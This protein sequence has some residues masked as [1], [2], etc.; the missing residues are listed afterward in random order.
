LAE[1]TG[2][3]TDARRSGAAGEHTVVF[4]GAGVTG[5]IARRVFKIA[6]K[7]PIIPQPGAEISSSYGAQRKQNAETASEK[8]SH[9]SYF[10]KIN[11]KVQ[12]DKT[13]RPQTLVG[14]SSQNLPHLRE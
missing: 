6:V 1:L 5:K 2:V 13:D 12:L 10:E 4:D 14:P 11:S 3:E 7:C 9:K 8:S